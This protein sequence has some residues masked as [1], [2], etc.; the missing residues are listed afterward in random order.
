MVRSSDVKI[1]PRDVGFAPPI[2]QEAVGQWDAGITFRFSDHFSGSLN[3]TNLTRTVTRQ[4][5]Q[6]AP[7]NMGSSWFDPGRSYRM[8]MTYTF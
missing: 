3:A 4:T 8:Q 6:Q 7:G 1:E 5:T 2:W